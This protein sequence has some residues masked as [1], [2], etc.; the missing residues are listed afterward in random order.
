MHHVPC[1][2]L[3]FHGN[4]AQRYKLYHKIITS[5]L[6]TWLHQIMVGLRRGGMGIC[7]VVAWNP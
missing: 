7:G 2:P 4:L 3:P 1:R 6:A 5:N